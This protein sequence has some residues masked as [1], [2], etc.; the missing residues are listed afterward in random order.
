MMSALRTCSTRFAPAPSLLTLSQTIKLEEME[1]K[2]SSAEA[3]VGDLAR[4]VL[5]MEEN[6]VK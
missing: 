1:K 4:R 6:S 3:Q 5:L 2:A